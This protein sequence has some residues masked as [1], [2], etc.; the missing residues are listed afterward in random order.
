MTTRHLADGLMQAMKARSHNHCTEL[1]GLAQGKICRMHSGVQADLNLST[2][3]H[4]HDRSGVPLETLIGWYR[5]RP[6][7]ALG[8]ININPPAG[9]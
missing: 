2:F 6:D 9:A 1:L 5:M 8:R 7:Q 3:V 4:I